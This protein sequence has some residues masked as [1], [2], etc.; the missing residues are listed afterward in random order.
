MGYLI[1]LLSGEYVSSSDLSHCS[2]DLIWWTS[3]TALLQLSFIWQKKRIVHPQGVRTGQPQRRSSAS[4][5]LA[6]SFYAFVSSPTLSLSYANWPGQEGGVFV[7]TK[8]LTRGSMDFLLF[9][10][11]GLFFLSFSHCHF[12]LLFPILTT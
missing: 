5:L 2:K 3:V 6:S 7:S 9:H 1:S 4:V 12:G 10:F 11:H 8:V